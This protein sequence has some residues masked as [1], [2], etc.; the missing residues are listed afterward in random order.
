MVEAAAVAERAEETV[1]ARRA[2]PWAVVTVAAMAVAMAAALAAEGTARGLEGT[3]VQ[4]AAVTVTAAVGVAR[5]VKE[6]AMTEA[7][8][9]AATVARTDPRRAA[10]M[11]CGTPRQRR[12]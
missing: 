6:V 10:S 8:W 12:S 1:M 7:A 5:E 3:A 11:W 2:A 9:A 4:A